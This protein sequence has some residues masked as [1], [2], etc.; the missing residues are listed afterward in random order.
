MARSLALYL[1]TRPEP[2]V[3]TR[4]ALE[5]SIGTQRCSYEG[6]RA[7]DNETLCMASSLQTFLGSPGVLSTIMLRRKLIAMRN[8]MQRRCSYRITATSRRA[9]RM[10]LALRKSLQR[11]RPE[12]RPTT[13]LY[14][15][16]V[17]QRNRH[18][19]ELQ[20]LPVLLLLTSQMSLDARPH[21]TPCDV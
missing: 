1:K 3:R 9:P 21:G 8:A 14:I 6:T 15:W 17:T 13:V 18:R 7:L 5:G 4:P 2:A 19:K 11:S 12:R 10:P 20:D 16:N